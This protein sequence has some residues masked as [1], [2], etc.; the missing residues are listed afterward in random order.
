MYPPK[1]RYKPTELLS[2]VLSKSY[3]THLRLNEPGLRNV[4]GGSHISGLLNP[5]TLEANPNP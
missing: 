5:Q 4:G 1:T 2:S 3:E